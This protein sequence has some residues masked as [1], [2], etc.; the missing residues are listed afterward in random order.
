M[1]YRLLNREGNWADFRRTGLELGADGSLRLES[2]PLATPGEPRSLDL[3]PPTGPAGVAALPS[4][5]VLLTDPDSPRLFVVDGCDSSH[6]PVPCRTGPGRGPDQLSAPRGLLYH[7]GRRALL[8]ADSGNGRILLLAPDTLE[9]VEIWD[10]RP[11]APQSLARDDAG[12]VYVADPAARRVDKLDVYGDPVPGF[13]EAG[14]ATRITPTEVAVAGDEV[15]VLER[16]SGRVHVLAT[17][18]ARRRSWRTEIVDPIGFTCCGETVYVGDNARRRLAVLRTDSTAIGAAYGYS[19]PVAAVACDRDGLLVHPGDGHRPIRMTARGAYRT[20][21]RMWGGPFPN[22]SPV[23]SPRHLVRAR[24]EA[25]GTGAHIQLYVA[26]QSA[27][28]APPPVGS[29]DDAFARPPWSPVAPD[30]AETL[31]SGSPGDEVWLALA[32]SSE[33]LASPVLHQIR[34]D[35]AHDTY[36]EHLPALYQRDPASRDVLARWLTVFESLFDDVQDEIDEVPRLFD[37]DAAPSAWLSWLAG[38]LALDVPEKWPD[39]RRRQA[40]SDGFARSGRR[41]TLRGLREALRDEAGVE[42]VIEEPILQTGWWA[43]AGDDATEAETA[44]SSLGATTVLAAGEP[45]GAVAG[46]SAVLDGSFLTPQEAY[47]TP[48]FTDVA[49]QFSVRLYRGPAY[50]AQT[51]ANVRAVLDRERPAH[52]TYQLCVVEPCLRV[53]FQARVGVDAIVGGPSGAT[54]LADEGSPG[55]VLGGPPPGRIGSTAEL[56]RTY[57]TDSATDA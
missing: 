27:G 57:L 1:P 20:R 15:L 11:G 17:D 40:V 12:N 21:G 56:G 36:L 7:P 26:L 35:F 39:E 52:T 34:L 18:G 53:G 8:V 47:A 30:A 33:G 5:D 51:L 25:L 19:G 37:P 6:R 24:L 32:F 22:P 29:G 23:S 3:G 44:L 10:R 55:L 48:L 50:S 46:T 54:A 31:V 42:A 28:G 49:H 13:W 38:W 14:G 4:G 45:Q 16:S 43:L 2:L 41:G 9:L